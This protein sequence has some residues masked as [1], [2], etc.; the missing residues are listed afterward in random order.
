[1]ETLRAA[2]A[3]HA[4]RYPAMEP[5]DAVKLV[6]Q[7][8]FG[9]GHLIAS[10]AQSLERLRAEHGAAAHDPAVPLA[11]DIGD[12]MDRIMKLSKNTAGR[13]LS[14]SSVHR[15]SSF[16]S[17]KALLFLKGAFYIH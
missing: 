3:A 10:P 1:M 4:G 13:S 6:Y 17:G 11:E 7:N 14:F 8:E 12:G 5:Q 9:G 16:K 15:F 2:L